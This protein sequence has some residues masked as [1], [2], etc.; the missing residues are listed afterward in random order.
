ME[1]MN[2]LVELPKATEKW[3]PP[4]PEDFEIGD[5]VYDSI[6]KVLATVREVHEESV[7]VKVDGRFIETA[8]MKLFAHH[9][10]F[11]VLD[12]DRLR[13]GSRVSQLLTG[14]IREFAT[15]IR[16]VPHKEIIL[17]RESITMPGGKIGPMKAYIVIEKTETNPIEMMCM[18][19]EIEEY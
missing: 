3:L 19:W 1:A 11:R 7:I 10:W 8:P 6:R 12:F 14:G 9:V 15:V 2:T 17:K 16:V 13:V 5:R 4:L 18:Q